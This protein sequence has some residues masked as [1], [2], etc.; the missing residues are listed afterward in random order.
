[1][2]LYFIALHSVS[3]IG[4]VITLRQ[5]RSTKAQVTLCKYVDPPHKAVAARIDSMNVG[6]C[7]DQF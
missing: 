5:C 1:M 3:Y 2:P 6:E 7:S 4:F